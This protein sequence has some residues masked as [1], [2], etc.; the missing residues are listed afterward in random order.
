MPKETVQMV[1]PAGTVGVEEGDVSRFE[2]AGYVTL[3][4]YKRDTKETPKAHRRNPDMSRVVVPK[5]TPV[6]MRAPDTAS[7]TE[8]PEE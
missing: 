1:G 4:K 6:T 5:I 2:S 3:E 8:D 7:I